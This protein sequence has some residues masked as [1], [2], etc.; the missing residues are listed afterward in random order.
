[1]AA[2]LP[3]MLKWRRR[4]DARRWAAAA[5]A[6]LLLSVAAL[7]TYEYTRASWIV[8]PWC[9]GGKRFVIGSDRDLL[10]DAR[11]YRENNPGCQ[12]DCLVNSAACDPK[13]VWADAS[14]ARHSLLLHTLYVAGVPIFAV[15]I[16]CASQVLSCATART[17]KP[18]SRAR[19]ARPRS[20]A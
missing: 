16:L 3:A 10:P 13:M 5:L 8:Q 6:G 2:F 17:R 15:S 14:I 12:A 4:Q 1:V 11:V 20:A 9:G 18:G 19:A 7:L